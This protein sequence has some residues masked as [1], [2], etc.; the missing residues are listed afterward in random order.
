MKELWNTAKKDL[1]DSSQDL[2]RDVNDLMEFAKSKS[3]SLKKSTP[4]SKKGSASIFDLA[5]NQDVGAELLTHYKDEWAAIHIETEQASKAAIKMDS[6]LQA[7]QKSVSQS[8]TVISRCRDE[9]ETLSETVEAVNEVQRKV[10]KL[11]EFLQ[12]VEQSIVEY[13]RQRARLEC[14]R[15]KDSQRIQLDK[16]CTEQE[17][18]LE[19]LK[20]VLEDEKRLLVEWN[21][22][23]ENQK[24]VARQQTFQEIFDQQMADYRQSGHLDRPV[25]LSN[26][27]ERSDSNLEEMIIE[28]KDG[29]ASLNEFLSDVVLE[30]NGKET[31]NGEKNTVEEKE[32]EGDGEEPKDSE[33]TEDKAAD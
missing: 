19:H 15:K 1:V 18:K 2:K 16:H 22:D 20:N 27:R 17:A 32:K 33:K 9:F 29:T 3:V 14:D 28:D 11:G 26:E 10:D 4:S 13:A 24:L 6:D 25:S 12:E 21:A 8:H 30:D 23:Q 7:I 31:E 5:V